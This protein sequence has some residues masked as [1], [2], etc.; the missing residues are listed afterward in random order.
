MKI[1]F[2]GAGSMAEA[3]MAGLLKQQICTK[4]DITVTNKQDQQRLE[5]L[6][7]KYGVATLEDKETVVKNADVIFLAMKPKD[8]KDGIQAIKSYVTKEQLIVSVLAGISTE[9][10]QDLFEQ[11]L[12]VIRSMPNTSAAI[13]LSATAIAKGSFATESDLALVQ[14]LFSAIG[15]CTIVEED[16]LHA[17][18]GVSGSGPAYIYYIAEAMEK[19]ALAQGLDMDVAKKLVSQTLIGAAH[20]LQETHKDAE[21][22]RKEVTSPG[23]TTQRGITLLEERKVSEAFESCI[24]GATERS[25]EMGEEMAEKLKEKASK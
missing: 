25:R 7:S 19:A 21:V 14:S 9:V 17:V 10:I 24:E 16:Q 13:G 4:E 18:T 6:E 1:A 22:L 2:I 12:R 11:E 8:A 3:I 15:L 20:M 5:N 23:G